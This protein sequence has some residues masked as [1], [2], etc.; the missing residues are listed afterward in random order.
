MS[1]PLKIVIVEDDAIIAMKI[2][3]DLEEAGHQIVGLEH[4]SERALDSIANQK[5][6]LVLLDINI[7]GSRDGIEIGIILKEKYQTPFIFI[8]AYSDPITLQRAKVAAPCAYLVKPYKSA[9]LHSSITIGLFN[10][11]NR[12]KSRSYSL[13]EIN[14]VA[15]SP[16]SSREFQIFENILAGLSNAQIAEKE[17]IS[18]NTVKWHLQNIFSKLDVNSRTSAISKL[19]AL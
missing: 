18:L 1:T 7:E 3:S 19:V 14:Q 12:Q 13:E 4:N 11:R 9:D 10:H 8:T 15:S 16:L 6:D 2:S 17:S 5:P